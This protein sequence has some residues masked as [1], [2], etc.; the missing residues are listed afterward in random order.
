MQENSKG[1]LK[2]IFRK[3]KTTE[4]SSVAEFNEFQMK[5]TIP[6]A[7]DS[8]NQLIVD[9]LIDPEQLDKVTHPI[10][11]IETAHPPIEAFFFRTFSCFRE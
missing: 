4:T 9:A 8:N 2:N 11:S 7:E 6:L 10:T 3:S 5:E 1:Y